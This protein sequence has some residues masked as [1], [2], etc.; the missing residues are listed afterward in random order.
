MPPLPLPH[1]LS[2]D[3]TTRDY[4]ITPMPPLRLPA[5]YDTLIAT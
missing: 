5:R 3:D 1:M 2:P 4:A